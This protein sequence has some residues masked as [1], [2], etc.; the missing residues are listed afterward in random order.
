VGDE[1]LV[2]EFDPACWQAALG[3][4]AWDSGLVDSGWGAGGLL[5][6]N[7]LLQRGRLMGALRGP[8]VDALAVEENALALLDESVRAC[9]ARVGLID[10]PVRG[11]TRQR[12]QAQAEQ[13]KTL[14]ALCPERRWRLEDLSAEVGVSAF[15]LARQFAQQVGMPIHRYQL[16]TRL[17]QSI[18]HV[19]EPGSDLLAIALR[20]GFNS[21]S[22]FT[23]AFRSTLGT[24]PSALRDS[25]V[26]T[27]ARIRKRLIA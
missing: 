12:R 15:H 13:V 24:T 3:P 16:H 20:F 4:A 2:L 11:A 5:P 8:A 9:R 26:A 19:M 10:R 18:D 6:P 23:A 1:V 17:A 25:P 7:A 21:H 22:H 14:L 27:A